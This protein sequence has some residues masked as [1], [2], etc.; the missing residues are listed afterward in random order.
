[1][2]YISS[3]IYY[4]IKMDEINKKRKIFITSA[5][6]FC[7]NVFHAGNLTGSTLSGDVY[8]RFQRKMGN[9]VM[10]ICGTDN[11]GTQTE[12]KAKKE[13]VTPEELCK[14]YRNLHEKGY[15][16]FNISFDVF[17]ETPTSIH[18]ELSQE[19]FKKLWE[20]NLLS[21]KKSEQ[22]FCEKCKMFLCDRFLNGICY[23]EKCE[24][25][26]KGD[27]CGKCNKFIDTNKLKKRWC[28]I[29]GE[30]PVKKETNHLYFKLSVFKN[31][32]RE[33]F[34]NE[35]NK[36]GIKYIS[37]VAKN[38]TKEW[39]NKELEDRSVT[40]DIKFAVNVPKLEGLERYEDK[41][42][43]PWLDAP[44][45]YIS[46]LANSYPE[47]W[48]EWVNKEVDW[49]AFM[50]KDNVPFHTI[51]FPSTLMG[52]DFE[53]LG[54]GITH[55]SA[56]DY[57]LFNGE[58]FSKS[59]GIG[60]FGDQIM[61]MSEKLE[62]DE[63]YWRYYLM[64]IRPETGDST[65]TFEGFCEVMKGELAQKMGNLVNRGLVMVK[66]YYSNL[67]EIKYQIDLE[68]FLKLKT[69]LINY[70]KGFDGFNYHEGINIINRIAEIGNEWINTNVLWN[71]CKNNPVESEH[72]MGNLLFIIWMFS[73]LIEPIMP[74]KS[75]K[76]KSYFIESTLAS[77]NGKNKS[78]IID[79]IMNILQK[80]N[81]KIKISMTSE[82]NIEI[83]FKQ[84]KLEDI[85]KVC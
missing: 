36:N 59:G 57:L 79:E 31:E 10:Y 12:L 47:S 62:I 4:F 75:E 6:P 24:G 83:L 22:Y 17:G 55:L 72:L 50:A 68:L 85:L 54:C 23:N 41:T 8:A 84:I 67:D 80:L 30:I 48:K 45:G 81:G 5:L 11:Y 9:D 29:C 60:I 35:N 53:N 65:F 38:I 51:I 20:N 77:E 25:L 1:M 14:K 82:T 16:W 32:I 28:S 70:I 63:D 44:I 40:R 66:K 49:V 21:E 74:K 3:Q 37:H 2:E 61:Y 26:V 39:M 52:S 19:I 46:I 13:N 7:N 33:Y 27:E 15:K 34:L 76:I 78:V 42:I 71:V 73:E 56:T 58:K 64:K 69:C 43:L 18:T